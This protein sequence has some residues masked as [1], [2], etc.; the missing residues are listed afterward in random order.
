MSH[1]PKLTP[2]GKKGYLT[3]RISV[4][5][6]LKWFSTGTADE[7]AARK[8]QLRKLEEIEEK[9]VPAHNERRLLELYKNAVVAEEMTARVAS[10]G[11]KNIIAHAEAQ[12]QRLGRDLEEAV[13]CAYLLDYRNER[14]F[15]AA[16]NLACPDLH[17]QLATLRIETLRSLV[18]DTPT[19]DARVELGAGSGTSFSAAA[20]SFLREN[21]GKAKDSLEDYE[22]MVE[23]VTAIVGD[24]DVGHYTKEDI[25]KIKGV[26][27]A[28]PAN[29]KKKK[30]LR[31]LSIVDA[32]QRTGFPNQAAKTINSKQACIKA[33]FA[34]AEENYDGVANPL[35]N[36]K[37]WA[38]EK[39][40][41]GDQWD[42][43]T[44]R[45]L[46]SLLSSLNASSPLFWITRLGLYTGMR[47]NEICQLRKSDVRLTA[48]RSPYLYLGD[49]Q[50]KNPS[51]VR[52]VPLHKTLVEEGFLTFVN[53]LHPSD[54]PLFPGLR[55][56]RSGRLSDDV[57]KKF[58][59][60][61]QKFGLK[62][63]KLSFHSLRHTFVEEFK[64]KCPRD[65]ESRERI[66]GHALLGVK[67]R[68]GSN[69]KAE[70]MDEEFINARATLVNCLF[71]SQHS[72]IS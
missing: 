44:P 34:Y 29:W 12:K 2:R 68:Y 47:L 60:H 32:A 69:Y 55:V 52:S 25:K 5:G 66:V 1:L 10:R 42:A 72:Q 62:R 27:V 30:E 40:A 4:D 28:L 48:E 58:S 22:A 65:E 56:H 39:V 41:A 8:E 31:G 36:S 54:A 16:L 18:A 43:F 49:K 37:P 70:A 3:F 51:S 45:E 46:G 35:A 7:R 6:K 50:L 17:A 61:L 23:A 33:I 63:G 9:P 11:A 57:G 26:I 20:A 14:T 38:R 24:K 15:L 64:K 13:A 53:T 21:K 19:T 67:G 71:P 59:R